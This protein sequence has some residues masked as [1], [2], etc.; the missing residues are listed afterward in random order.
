MKP[1]DVI[2]LAGESI[3]FGE[4]IRTPRGLAIDLRR[5]ASRMRALA[6]RDD[7]A[8]RIVAAAVI[9]GGLAPLV[10]LALRSAAA[11]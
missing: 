11:L 2:F 9:F 4:A 1:Q 5:L 8:T 10:L 7:L 3:P 6:T